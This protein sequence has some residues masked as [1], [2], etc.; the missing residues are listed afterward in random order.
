MTCC[1][2]IYCTLT[3]KQTNKTKNRK[4][5]YNSIYTSEGVVVVSQAVSHY[6]IT[7]LGGY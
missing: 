1:R 4:T 6:P 2:K 3:M 5:P 7:V